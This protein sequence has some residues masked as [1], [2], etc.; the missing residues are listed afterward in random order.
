MSG[1]DTERYSVGSDQPAALSKAKAM[2]VTIM[3][4]LTKAGW[5]REIPFARHYDK[6]IVQELDIF[7]KL[8]CN[9]K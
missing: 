5:S 9:S 3:H 2:A 6:E 8:N 7:Q 1:V 4:I